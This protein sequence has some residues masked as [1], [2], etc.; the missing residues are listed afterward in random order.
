MNNTVRIQSRMLTSRN[1]PAAT[2]TTVKEISLRLSP[3][4][5]L[6]VSGIA[7]IVT[8]DGKASVYSSHFTLAMDYV[9]SAPT[10]ISAGA[11][12]RAL[13]QF[14]A[15]RPIRTGATV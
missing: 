1:F 5:M 15:P 7:T 12:R 9:I 2:F 6:K 13:D 14:S 11:V 3:V 4:A 8:N 10:R